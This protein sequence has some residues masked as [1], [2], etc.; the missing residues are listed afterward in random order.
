MRLFTYRIVHDTGAAPNP[1]WGRCTLAIC[2]PAIRRVAQPGDWV[3]AT[4]S[5][6]APAGDLSRRVVYMMRVGETMAMRA[7]DAYTRDLLPEKIPDLRSSDFRRRAGD[8]IYDFTTEPPTLRRSVHQEGNRRTDL[9]GENVLISD[10]FFYFGHE[11]VPL[12]TRLWPIIKK[13]QGHKSTAN[14]S[15]LAAFLRWV[16]GLKL[17]PGSILG[18]PIS[19]LGSTEAWEVA[20]L[21]AQE[22]RFEA[23]FHCGR[24]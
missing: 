15:Y 19:P 7:Y 1:F 20:R 13:G 24:P 11:A 22:G 2:K 3:A 10:H 9:S 21:H 6:V 8:S 4:G 5:A 18:R 14:D 12:P 17:E 23:K 16:D